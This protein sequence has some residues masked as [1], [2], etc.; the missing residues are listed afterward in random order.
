MK[1][2]GQQL[3]ELLQE[4]GATLRIGLRQQGHLPIVERMRA[5]GASWDEIG[6]AIGWAGHAVEKWYAMETNRVSDESRKDEIAKRIVSRMPWSTN[7]DY[8]RGLDAVVEALTD[9]SAPTAT[10]EPELRAA[11]KVAIEPLEV[12]ASYAHDTTATVG[13]QL[14]GRDCQRALDAI[15][16]LLDA[17][18]PAPTTPAS[19]VYEL[20][21]AALDASR[22]YMNDAQYSK[23]VDA[24]LRVGPHPSA[25]AAPAET[26][27]DY[28]KLYHFAQEVARQ[29]DALP[30]WKKP[31]APVAALQEASGEGW[32]QRIA[33]PPPEDGLPFLAYGLE[34]VDEDYT[35]DG[36]VEACYSGD[37]FIGAIWNNCSDEWMTQPIE[38]THWMRAQPP[39]QNAVDAL[40]PAPP[41]RKC[42]V[43]PC[44]AHAK[45]SERFEAHAYLSRLIVHYAPQCEPLPTLLGVCSQIDNLL[46]ALPPAPEV[47]RIREGMGLIVTGDGANGQ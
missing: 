4:A 2:L 43:V 30:D 10:R 45:P 42:G 41:C 16:P 33:V 17:E 15:R 37:V 47:K 9:Y 44:R 34:L 46:E 23:A 1:N 35:P 25:P 36:I 19:T 7:A 38:F 24:M 22:V 32:Q 20:L 31:G 14:H 6:S 28:A 5:E 8:R 12:A 3:G 26:P 40:P 13:V 39:G 11:L 29:A 18:A 27:E 21:N